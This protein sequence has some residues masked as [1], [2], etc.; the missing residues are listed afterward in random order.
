MQRWSTWPF[1]VCVVK[2]VIHYT[3]DT[4][5]IQ[6]YSSQIHGVAPNFF[7]SV[8]DKNDKMV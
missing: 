3:D 4:I 6:E 7:L 5:C 8:F 1:L 2:D